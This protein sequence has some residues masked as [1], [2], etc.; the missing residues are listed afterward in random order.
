MNFTSLR[1]ITEIP[2]ASA[3]CFSEFFSEFLVSRL[4][5]PASTRGRR[6]LSVRGPVSGRESG[7][8]GDEALQPIELTRLRGNDREVENRFWYKINPWR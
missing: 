4:S 8:N 6:F 3:R 5:R 1:L 7:D 2:R